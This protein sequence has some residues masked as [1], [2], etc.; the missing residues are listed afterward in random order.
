[1][2]YRKISSLKTAAQFQAYV[3]ELGIELPVDEQLESG[4]QSPLAQP[5]EQ[6]GIPLT[7]RF[8][9]LPMEGWDGTSDGRPTEYTLRRWQRFGQS[10]AGLI[11]GGEAVAIRPDG[12]ANP[13]QLEI[14]PDTVSD[15]AGLRTALVTEYQAATGLAESPLIG[16]Q[17][18]HSG[19]FSRPD[20]PKKLNPRL[21]YDHPLL[22]PRF[23]LPPVSGK[24]FTDAEIDGLIETFV[25]AAGLAQQAG[26]DFVDIKHCHGYLLHEFLSAVSRPGS[27]GGSLENRTRIARD[28]ITGIQTHVPGMKIGVRL[29]LFDMLPFS[30]GP[31]RVGQPVKPEGEIPFAF[32][33]DASGLGIDLHEPIAFI[34]MLRSLGV[35]LICLTAGSPYYN[36]HIQRPAFY[37]PSDGYLPPEDPLVG[38]ARQINASA[39]IK[40]RFPDMLITGSGYSYL[41][42]WL[43]GVAQA[44]IRRGMIDTVGLGRSVL[45]YPELSLDVLYGRKIQTKHLCRT[46]SDCTTG[47][48]NGLISGCYPLDPHYKALPEAKTLAQIKQ[49]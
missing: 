29:S 34:E 43:P 22:N 32:G 1:M 15:L 25:R 23:G 40:A 2:D 7:N 6:G 8:A 16:L 27:Y 9:I 38:V 37:P 10:G 36:P 18:T 49:G 20:H 45:S 5:V 35:R 24:I 42:E 39:Q 31:D 12:R 41:Q 33:A 44:V 3:S 19:R 4:P 28:V 11:W 13:N 17:L 21:A 26:F 30:P 48:R 47:P 46:F 14:R